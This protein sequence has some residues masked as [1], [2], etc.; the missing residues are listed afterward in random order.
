MSPATRAHRPTPAPE[1]PAVHI[2]RAAAAVTEVRG[3]HHLTQRLD[4]LIRELDQQ[5]RR[6]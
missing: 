5:A 1:P 3:A 2:I 4:Q 6:P